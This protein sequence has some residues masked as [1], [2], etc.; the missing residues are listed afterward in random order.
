MSLSAKYNRTPYIVIAIASFGSLLMA[1]FAIIYLF[2]ILD[3][4][5]HWMI[6]VAAAPLSLGLAVE[7]SLAAP[8]FDKR[9]VVVIDQAGILDLRSMDR[10]LRWNEIARITETKN[11]GRDCFKIE[12][13]SPARDLMTSLGKRLRNLLY[14]S[15]KDGYVLLPPQGL[16]VS[17]DHIR[18]AF[19]LHSGKKY[20]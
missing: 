19:K 13:V 14:G 4:S 17:P 7:M 5:E 1:V 6:Y 12:L 16:T 18:A 11:E 9:D 2:K 15:V 3:P 8:L 10:P 20:E